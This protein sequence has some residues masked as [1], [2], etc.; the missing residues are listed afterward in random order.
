MQVGNL[1][2]FQ[3]H[4]W[5]PMTDA[6]VYV[7][8]LQVADMTEALGFD[9]I[10]C[11]EHH[12]T[13]Y[14]LSPNIIEFLAYMAGRTTRLK[15]GTAAVILPWHKDP[16]RVA[17]D[18][19]LLDNLSGGRALAGFG[20]G[21]AQIEY[22]GFGIPMEESR[23]RMNEAAHMILQGLNTGFMEGNGQYFKQERREIRPRPIRSFEDRT[24]V[25][26]MS[27]DT[28]PHAAKIGGALMTFAIGP[29]E[30]RKP[31]IDAW[32]E[33]YE[34]EWNRPAPPSVA[35]VIA[36]CDTDAS[37]AHDVAHKHM[38]E[39]WNT[40][41]AHYE[42]KGDHFAGKGGQ[43]DHYAKSAAAMRHIGDEGMGKMFTNCQVYGTPDQIL[44]QIKGIE[45]LV[46]DIDV[47]VTF[48]YAGLPY[49]QAK[50]SMKL[51]GEQVLPVLKNGW[52][53][54]K[55]AAG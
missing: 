21:L 7:N 18:F 41:T 51:F 45:D 37:R 2:F 32:R 5:L 24:Y 50:Q 16:L 38:A 54:R 11:T 52:A 27:P 55:A 47:N 20:R 31:D 34:K 10:W 8:E 6:E 46:G 15:L 35:N 19:A 42:M 14:L 40:A 28:V 44:Q 9:S 12:F 3:N 25:V 30:K 23:G 36:Y 4:P 13:D 43:Y 26:S 22:D 17:T 48:S 49:D 33:L 53:E 39:Y 1:M 29:W